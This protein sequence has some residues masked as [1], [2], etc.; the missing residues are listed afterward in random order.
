[1]KQLGFSRPIAIALF[2]TAGLFLTAVFLVASLFISSRP[3]S[4]RGPLIGTPIRWNGLPVPVIPSTQWETYSFAGPVN[5]LALVDGLLWAATDGGLVV[6]EVAGNSAEAVKFTVDHGLAANRVTSVAIGRDDAVWAG[7]VGGLS[8]YDGREWQ[9]FRT[10]DGLP[11][12]VIHDLAIDRDGYVWVATSSGLG[13]YDGRNWRTF[14]DRGVLAPLPG[15]EVISLAV[16]P[17][18]RLWVG[19]NQGLA[20]YDGRWRSFLVN[21]GL[22]DDRIE[23]LAIGP[24]G[25]IWL[26]TATGLT[27]YDGQDWDTFRLHLSADPA[28]VP[29]PRA[30]APAGDGSVYVALDDKINPL[31]RLDPAIG[32]SSPVISDSGDTFP[33]LPTAILAVDPGNLWVGA[34]EG[35]YHFDGTYWNHWRA[36]SELPASHIQD[37]LYARESL[38]VA[39]T[40]GIARYDGSWR[41]YGPDEGLFDGD[42]AA[43]AIDDN[44]LI[45][46]IS[47][48]PQ[49]GLLR[50]N[51]A[52]DSW[53]SVVCPVE[54]PTGLDINAAIQ[55]PDGSVW[56][57]TESGISRFDGMAW[58]GYGA[59]EGLPNSAVDALV[60]DSMGTLWA[61]A[62][63]GLYRF[64]ASQW[65]LA[66]PKPVSMLAAGLD[67]SLWAMSEGRVYR[68]AAEGLTPISELPIST[69][70]RGMAAT[71]GSVWLATSDGVFVFDGDA[72]SVHLTIDGLPS[73][74][75]TAIAANGEQVW[76]ATSGDAQEIE[77]VTYDGQQWRPHP[78]RIPAAEQLLSNIIRDIQVTPGGELWLA[79]PSGINRLSDGRWRG[80][81][82]DNGLPGADVRELAW[83]YDT[84]WAATNLGLARF[85]GRSWESFG[86]TA[87]DQPGAGVS[88]LVV[89]VEGELW[90]GL[91]EGWP[92]ALR[93]FDGQ[94]WQI[95]PLRSANTRIR[96]LAVVPDGRLISLVTDAGRPYVGVYD[97]LDW[98][99]LDQNQLP[100]Q[101]GQIA[102]DPAGRLWVIGRDSITG[103]SESVIAILEI[104][105]QGIGGMIARFSSFE[106]GSGSVIDFVA[107]DRSVS[108]HF[109]DD[110]RA[111]VGGAG[112]VY[113][114][115][116]SQDGTIHMAGTWPIPLP[117]SR[118]TFTLAADPDGNIW[119]GTERGVAVV[120]GEN[121]AA[122]PAAGQGV[123]YAPPSTPVWWGSVRTMTARPDGG[124]L[125]GTAA[126]GMGIYTGREFDGVLHPSQ[127]PPAWARS[128]YPIDA[129]LAD[130]SGALWVGSE[131]GGAARFSGFSW[132]IFSPEP[133]LIAPVNALAIS[134]DRGWIGTTAGL[135]VVIDLNNFRCR[136]EDI[137]GGINPT[138]A[139]RDDTGELWAATS[140]HG[141]VRGQEAGQRRL[142]ELGSAPVP[143]LASAPN[144]D[145]WFAN[146]HLPW[147]TRYRQAL[148]GEDGET[149]NRLPLNPNVIK[150]Q[151]ITAL[152]VSPNQDI[153]IGGTNSLVRFSGG[154]WLR[155]TTHEGLADN[156]VQH[157]LALADGSVWVATPGGLSR[158]NP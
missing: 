100:F 125:L 3:L 75:V 76:V 71:T 88:S 153:W 95:I 4:S 18:N 80:Y 85:N 93:V 35:V 62:P 149:W 104:T 147:L 26:V 90:M 41:Y 107:D 150:P 137:D 63:D 34:S 19:T 157:L 110:G 48:T 117:F 127:G 143:A 79:T 139:I 111:Y 42:M 52:K 23:S 98:I 82:T 59:R 7:T 99:W 138:D 29:A 89:G 120:G 158:Y 91:D 10:T 20:R 68:L 124:I 116:E 118:H 25:E 156:H 131:G 133:T 12:D 32:R 101:I 47:R 17:A 86:S 108:F 5:D 134:G 50:L 46:A 152:A 57:A 66:D 51:P 64:E 103:S 28:L 140:E 72:W 70:V 67:S 142:R 105:P 60:V 123:Y 27:R 58:Q 151:E 53:E 145:V 15:S 122:T 21:D 1:V 96:Q 2:L 94:G 39:T 109:A 14:S 31:I 77:I 132:Q 126:G 33:S 40:A 148:A 128:F 92:N 45:W 121:G 102:V 106:P 146:G 36:P 61:G 37:L 74:D 56:F 22:P 115:E 43:L 130:E 141:V 73:L 16:D 65:Q 6:W 119:A 24:A 55:G 11:A 155:L 8:R 30:V 144:G 112:A 9:T 154:S 13:R 49:A 114:F 78:N 97:G 38:W 69:V 113:V 81:S 44:G 135:I 129:V 87:H 54:A 83:A 84:L 136:I